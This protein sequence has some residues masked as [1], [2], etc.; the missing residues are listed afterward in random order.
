MFC[1]IHHSFTE[2]LNMLSIKPKERETSAN[3]PFIG[4]SL[5]GVLIKAEKRLIWKFNRNMT[6]EINQ[7]TFFI[8]K[9]SNC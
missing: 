6:E 2:V 9:C 4:I 5:I 8:R 3:H 1:V 7:C